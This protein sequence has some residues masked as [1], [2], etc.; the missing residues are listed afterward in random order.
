MKARAA[1]GCPCRT[2]FLGKPRG[3]SAPQ[4]FSV[5]SRPLS[6]PSGIPEWWLQTPSMPV[7]SVRGHLVS[8]YPLKWGKWAPETDQIAS[9]ISRPVADNGRRGHRTGRHQTN[10]FDLFF[11]EIQKKVPRPKPVSACPV[12]QKISARSN[13]GR[14]SAVGRNARAEGSRFSTSNCSH[15]SPPAPLAFAAPETC[16]TWDV[17][18]GPHAPRRWS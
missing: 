17:A 11:G 5:V 18:P 13:G 1:E 12:S 8:K 15:P 3:R 9:S 6:K 16:S 2:L 4:F 14:Q 10:L 7:K